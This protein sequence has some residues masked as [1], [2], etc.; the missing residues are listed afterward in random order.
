MGSCV[1]VLKKQS[2]TMGDSQQEG[3]NLPP[4]LIFHCGDSRLWQVE[5]GGDFNLPRFS[6]IDLLPW[7]P[8]EEPINDQPVDKGWT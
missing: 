8:P 5:D 6:N 3:E 4:A 7:L 2:R 1:N